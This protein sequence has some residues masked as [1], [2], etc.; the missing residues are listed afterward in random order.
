[1]TFTTLDELV[2]KYSARANRL[3]RFGNYLLGLSSVVG[4]LDLAGE[5]IFPREI[6]HPG[7][8]YWAILFSFVVGGGLS[9]WA[10][11]KNNQIADFYY[12]QNAPIQYYMS[13]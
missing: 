7:T 8:V 1:M 12:E 6:I 9:R 4:G 2:K 11:R 5:L 10:A 13:Q 3:K